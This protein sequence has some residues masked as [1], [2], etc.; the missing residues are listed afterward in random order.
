[1]YVWYGT[2]DYNFVVLENPPHYEP[3]L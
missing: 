3:T 2:N 1:M